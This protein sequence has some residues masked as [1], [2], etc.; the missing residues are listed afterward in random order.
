MKSADRV[1]RDQIGVP[2][3]AGLRLE[4]QS[5]G[6]RRQQILRIEIGGL[7]QVGIQIPEIERVLFALLKIGSRQRVVLVASSASAKLDRAARIIG[8][9]KTWPGENFYCWRRKQG[10]RY[11]VV[12]ERSC[13]A[14]LP[15][16]GVAL[17]P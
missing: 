1:G 3:H 8:S 4:I 7:I 9:G 12:L 17:R 14:N 6:R 16:C 13:E 11:L 5:R 2:E 15:M 10:R